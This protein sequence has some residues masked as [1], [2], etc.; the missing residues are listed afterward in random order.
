MKI[1]IC[2]SIKFMDSMIEL[3]KKLEAGGHTIFMPFRVEGVDYWSEDNKGRVEAKKKLGLIHRHLA[4]IERSD[5]ILVAN[6]TKRDIENYIGANTFTEMAFAHFRKKKIFVLNPVP[7]QK[8]IID[9]LL[10]MDLILLDRDLS[11]VA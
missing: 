3:Q 8:Y 9:E 11:R 4:N 5:A 6:Y 2:G 7:D 10:S 1:T